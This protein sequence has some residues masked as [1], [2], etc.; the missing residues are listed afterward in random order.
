MKTHWFLLGWLILALLPPLIFVNQSI[1]YYLVPATAP[2][3][4][5]LALAFYRLVSKIISGFERNAQ[6]VLVIAC[7]VNG[8]IFV[9]GRI[10]LKTD[11]PRRADGWDHLVSKAL[12]ARDIHDR[13]LGQLPNQPGHILIGLPMAGTFHGT[14]GLQVW[15][16]DSTVYCQPLSW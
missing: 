8:I 7:C 16:R 10:N 4:I 3:A 2:A 13:L 12:I 14:S 6:V 1:R 9:Q 11:E 5:G 15:Y